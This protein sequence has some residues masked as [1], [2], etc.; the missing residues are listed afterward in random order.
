MA[1]IGFAAKQEANK[2]KVAAFLEQIKALEMKEKKDR[3]ELQARL[4]ALAE[5]YLLKEIDHDEFILASEEIT[6]WAFEGE[7]VVAAPVVKP[8]KAAKAAKG[9]VVETPAA[10][11]EVAEVIEEVVEK[12][13]GEK[14]W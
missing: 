4:G 6:G 11:E 3:V 1:K 9:A 8:A 12:P 14:L 2:A 5:Q 7:E 13:A 10:Q